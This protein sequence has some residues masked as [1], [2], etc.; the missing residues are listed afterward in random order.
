M[1]VSGCGVYHEACIKWL[2]WLAGMPRTAWW[3]ST[4]PSQ[5]ESHGTVA[6]R[7]RKP[8]LAP[9]CEQRN[10]RALTELSLVEEPRLRLEKRCVR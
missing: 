1:V 8:H 9:S 3:Y 6:Y 7:E 4:G 2:N 10:K 5:A